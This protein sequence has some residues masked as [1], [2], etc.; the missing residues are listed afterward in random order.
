MTPWEAVAVL[1]AGVAAGGINAVVGSGSL[2]TF[3]T[4][5]A[6]GYPPIV[7][8]VSNNVGLVAGG[9]AGVL[10]YRAELSGQRARLMRLGIG[11]VLGSLVGGLLLLWLPA[12]AFQVIVPVLIALAC[13]M[14]VAQ[15]KVNAWLSA[16]QSVPHPHGGPW[17]WLGVCAAGVYGGYFGAAQGVVLIGLLGIFFDDHLQRINAAKNMLSLLVNSTAAVLFALI[18]PVDWWVVLLISVGSMAG[19]FLGARVGRRLPARVLRGLVVCVGIVAII[20]L[21]YG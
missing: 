17:L 18:A 4:L 3:P 1:A 15:P 10:G 11:S 21:V 13:V 6:L 5:L 14:V 9:V 20:K 8:N 7:A 19:G 2:I 12:E 16:R